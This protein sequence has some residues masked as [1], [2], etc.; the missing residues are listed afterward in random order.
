MVIFNDLYCI[1]ICKLNRFIVY[2]SETP[3]CF[4]PWY[5]DTPTDLGII[6]GVG[7]AN[8][9]AV[10][11]SPPP[12]P[13]PIGWSR[14]Q[15]DPCWP[16]ISLCKNFIIVLNTIVFSD[17]YCISMCKL[18]CFIVDMSETPRYIGP[19]YRDIPTFW[20]YLV[21]KSMSEV[22]HWQSTTRTPAFWDT[23]AAPWLTILVIHIK[24]QVKTRQ[25][26]K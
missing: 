17:I 6:F 20:S 22:L 8:G 12:P 24:S 26:Y 15:N 18:N 19:W 16:Y 3:R 5:R 11:S 1:S 7:S 2:L 23:P 25:S 10:T 14:T 4:G 13:P 9:D 21:R